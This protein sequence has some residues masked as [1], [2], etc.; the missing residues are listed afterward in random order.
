MRKI[1]L[2][3]L[4]TACGTACSAAAAHAQCRPAPESNEAK[5]LAFYSAPLTFSMDVAAL[6]LAPGGIRLG[7]EGGPVP[8]PKASLRQT[9]AC[10]HSKSENSDLAPAFGR[11]R[12]AVGLPLG[13][14]VEASYIPPITIAD[15]EPNLAGLSLAYVFAPVRKDPF[16]LHFLT[17]AHATLGYVKGP[18]TCPEKALQQTSATEPCY[19]SDPSE[20]TF[21]PNTFGAEAALSVTRSDNRVSAYVGTGWNALRPRFQ[22]GFTDGNGVVD[23]TKVEVNLSRI[24]LFTG[25]VFNFTDRLDVSVQVYSV[26]QD[27]TTFKLGAGYRIR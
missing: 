10:F 8:D 17:R 9:G 24:A 20:D 13:F 27:V 11:P 16:T 5:L 7:F 18:I 15:A 6:R 2:L 23:N 14:V 4:G 19:G 21:R 1:L 26:P 3:I 22:V 12:V 25:G